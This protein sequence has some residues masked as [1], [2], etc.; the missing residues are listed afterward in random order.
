MATFFVLC[1]PEHNE[2]GSNLPTTPAFYKSDILHYLLNMHLR[3]ETPKENYKRRA[4]TLM[5]LTPRMLK[6][7]PPAKTSTLVLLISL[8]NKYAKYTFALPVCMN[9]SLFHYLS[10]DSVLQL[11]TTLP[12][13]EPLASAS[14]SYAGPM[15]IPMWRCHVCN[16]L[17][18]DD[19]LLISCP[20]CHRPVHSQCASVCRGRCGLKVCNRCL[21]MHP[22]RWA[23]RSPYLVFPFFKLISNIHRVRSDLRQI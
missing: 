22:C 2:R 12:S 16:I 3:L 14:T 8:P 20:D 13:V 4:A 23:P 5:L 6:A 1:L 21:S 9:F 7:Y 15:A 10:V 17:M 18:D 19:D 11:L